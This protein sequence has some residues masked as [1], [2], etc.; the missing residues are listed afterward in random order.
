MVLT[1]PWATRWK[2]GEL[3]RE[4]RISSNRPAFIAY[5]FKHRTAPDTI[6]IITERV[7]SWRGGFDKGNPMARAASSL[8][9]KHTCYSVDLE[10]FNRG[11]IPAFQA[12]RA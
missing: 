8:H 3:A 1:R 2:A 11:L 10:T 6:S 9:H 12:I 5:A 7:A 4:Q